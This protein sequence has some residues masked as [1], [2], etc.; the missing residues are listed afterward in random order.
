[1]IKIKNILLAVLLT[2]FLPTAVFSGYNHDFSA[3]GWSMGERCT[4]CHLVHN[5]TPGMPLWSRSIGGPGFLPYTASATMDATPIDATNGCL[6]CHDGT[7]AI[8]S[9]GTEFIADSANWGQDGTNDHPINFVFDAALAVQD[10]Q[11]ATPVAGWVENLPV[12]WMDCQTCHSIHG[13]SYP[14]L[15]RT[16]NTGSGLCLTC[17]LK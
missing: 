4:V 6:S 12:D 3:L 13:S 7:M 8:D 17:H 11:L 9:G 16:D 15:L 14:F 5:A 1:M 10:G 2:A